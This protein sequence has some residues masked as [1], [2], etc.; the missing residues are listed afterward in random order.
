L[1]GVH[2]PERLQVMKVCATFVGTVRTVHDRAPDGDLTFDV[3]PDAG[4]AW[5]LN[6][7]NQSK[8][9]IHMEIVPIDQAGCRSGCS[10]ANVPAPRVGAHVRLTGAWVYDR[11]VGW[12]EI[13]PTWKVEPVSGASPPPPPPPPPPPTSPPRVVHLTASLTGDGLGK[14]GANSGRGSVAL[15][16]TA[17]KLC[18][19]FAGV[20]QIGRPIGASVL[21]KGQGKPA[22]TVRRLGKR[23]HRRGCVA[24]STTL[25]ESVV[26]EPSSYYVIVAS[27]RHRHGAIRGRLAPS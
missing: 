1:A 20:T 17:E 15:T 2:D 7:K 27:T 4:Y 19:R 18:W 25:A 26:D 12:N 8:G 16:L 10:G 22:R 11:W 6:A 5:M 23:Y 14:R 13:H 24:L 21:F 3:T 9:G